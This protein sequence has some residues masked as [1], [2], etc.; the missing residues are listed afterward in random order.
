MSNESRMKFITVKDIYFLSAIVLIKVVSWFSSPKLK[1]FVVGG[2]ASAAYQLSRN[3]RRLSEKNLSETFDQKL[4]ENKI[5]EIVRGNFY[6]FWKETFSLPLSSREKTALKG[7]ELYG[8]EFLQETLK[9]ERGVILWESRCFGARTLAKQILHEN[10][11]LIDQ[12]HAENHLGGGFTTNGSPATWVRRHIIKPFFEKH[13]KQFVKEII[14][15]PASDSLAF[16]RVLLNLL[17]QN[18]IICISGDGT[19]GQKLIPLKFLG[20]PG[21]FSTGMVSMSK[22]SGAPILPIFCIQHRNG[23]TRL[24]IEKLIQIE[25]GL[26]REHG[27]ENSV[28]QYISL[29]ESYVRRYPE[30][31]WGWHYLYRSQEDRPTI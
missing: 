13:E 17:K 20:R 14:Y 12:V 18:T 7:A 22:I 23:K 21:F 29:L 11:F 30:N 3:K 2:I 5:R 19:T 27:L 24:I 26:D 6:A 28:A 15:L 8:I 10:G 1:K 31:Y 25:T 9:E 4:S 16:T